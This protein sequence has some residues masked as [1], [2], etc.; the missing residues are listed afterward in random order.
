MK[1]NKYGA[2]KTV[3][4]GITFDS[5]KEA[6]RYQELKILLRT[7]VIEQLKLQP[8]FDFIINGVKCGFYKADFQYWDV[9]IKKLI[10]ED[11]KGMKTP[12]YRLKKKL[13][14]A[15]HGIDIYET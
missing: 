9:R 2:K 14:L 8:R 4:D 15:L 10:T 1:P 7:G 12:V 13:M 3:V 6:I 11:V 5:K